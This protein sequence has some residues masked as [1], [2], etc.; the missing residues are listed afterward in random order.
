MKWNLKRDKYKG[1][2]V[3]SMKKYVDKKRIIFLSLTIILIIFTLLLIGFYSFNTISILKNIQEQDEKLIAIYNEFKKQEE[4]NESKRKIWEENKYNID[5]IYSSENN[6]VF[7][8][9]DDGPSKNTESILNILQNYGVKANFF[10]LGSRVEVMPEIVKNIYNQ[11]HFIG[12][13]GYSHVYE[14]IY[15]SP[16][17][18]YDEYDKTNKIVQNAIG[19]SDYRAKLFRFPGGFVGGKYEEIKKQA[20]QLL[21]ENQVL[22][23]DWNALTG[24]SESTKP[25][26]DKIM[27]NLQKTA[28]GKRSVVL[29]MHDSAAKKITAETL[30]QV[31][32]FFKNQGYEFKTF[33]D[34]LK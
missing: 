9:F 26:A 5:H 20:K 8:T 28:G 3:Y 16:Q 12:N 32:E 29:L 11:G 22:N 34:I 2:N 15:A 25:T 30:P 23:V 14:A 18:V 1:Y 24:D 10:V 7:L 31:I 13:H 33:N 21:E 19:N 6:R 17:S 27:E 4:E